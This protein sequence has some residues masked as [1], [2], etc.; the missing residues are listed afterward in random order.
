[1]YI[2]FREKGL[3]GYLANWEEGNT[4]GMQCGGLKLMGTFSFY[5]TYTSILFEYFSKQ[6]VV[7]NY[8]V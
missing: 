8:F 1:M 3:E 6:N 5:Y 4:V 2:K 7:M